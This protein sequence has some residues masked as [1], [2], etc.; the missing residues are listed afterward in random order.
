MLP[1]CAASDAAMELRPLWEFADGNQIINA[2]SR[3]DEYICFFRICW[4]TFP[5]APALRSVVPQPIA[6][7]CSPTSPL[8]WQSLT[9]RVR[10]SSAAAPRLPDADQT[11]LPRWVKRGIS[12][13]PPKRLPH[14]PGSS[15]TPG[16]PDARADASVH[17]AFRLRNS[18]GAQDMNL[19]EAQ[20]LAYAL[21]YRRFAAALAGVRARLRVDAV[22]PHRVGLPPTTPCRS[23]RRTAKDSGRYRAELDPSRHALALGLHGACFPSHRHPKSSADKANLRPFLECHARSMKLHEVLPR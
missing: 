7:P 16:C 3:H 4:S 20:L 21:P 8:L 15:T 12:R 9:S 23:P 5:L 13:F 10:A 18:V 6:R 2:C 14:T 19:C 22:L 1:I 11:A 17:V